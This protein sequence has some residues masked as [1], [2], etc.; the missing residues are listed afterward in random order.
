MKRLGTTQMTRDQTPQTADEYLAG[1]K[2]YATSTSLALL[3]EKAEGMHSWRRFRRSRREMARWRCR[4]G[5]LKQV[6]DME[7]VPDST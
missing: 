2:L 3:F 1:M 6:L 7:R 5:Q 4:K